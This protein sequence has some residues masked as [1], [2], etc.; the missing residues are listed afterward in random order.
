[1]QVSGER[2]QVGNPKPTVASA[3]VRVR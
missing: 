3:G 2:C 1:V